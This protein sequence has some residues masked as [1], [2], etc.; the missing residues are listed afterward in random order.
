MKHLLI[1]ITAV[2]LVACTEPQQNRKYLYDLQLSEQVR[3]F[4]DR[5]TPIPDSFAT[6]V[7]V[8][9]K[10]GVA[11]N[12]KWSAQGKKRFS[13]YIQ[14]SSGTLSAQLSDSLY[15]LVK[16]AFIN[17]PAYSDESLAMPQLSDWGAS[18]TEMS[19]FDGRTKA[20]ITNGNSNH[21]TNS[22]LFLLRHSR[23][24]NR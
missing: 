23:K 15:Y 2:L 17:L 19:T 6:L 9:A 24:A 20:S 16:Q 22:I 4:G 11:N 5:L 1:L 3:W 13:S 10:R 7:T 12:Y 18:K 21:H 14:K 8:Q